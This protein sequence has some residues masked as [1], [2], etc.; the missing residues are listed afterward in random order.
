[1]IVRKFSDAT[2]QLT[3]ISILSSFVLSVVFGGVILIREIR[4]TAS[5]FVEFSTEEARTLSREMTKSNVEPSSAHL[6]AFLESRADV[7]NGH[8]LKAQIVS[9]TGEILADTVEDV[10]TDSSPPY[11]LKIEEDSVG[12][13][14]HR[15][16]WGHQVTLELMLPV[17][18]ADGVIE[19]HLR[20]M[21]R[22]NQS[23]VSE[24]QWSVAGSVGET[25]LIV[26][27]TAGFIYPMVRRLNQNLMKERQ[28]MLEANIAILDGLGAAIAQRDSD[29]GSHNYR[30]TYYSIRLA[31]AA[32]LPPEQI[33]SLIKGAFLH[34]VGKIGVRD[35]ILLKPGKLTDVEFEEMKTHVD[36]GLRIVKQVAWLND[37]SD[38]VGGHHEKWNGSGYPNRLSKEN[39]P[40]NARVFAVA[41]VFDALTSRRP[42]KEPFPV[43]QAESIL[44]EGRN[45]HFDP[46]LVDLF[47]SRCRSLM[48]ETSELDETALKNLLRAAAFPYFETAN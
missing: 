21:Y 27:L 24:A 38:V 41:D 34:D 8:L 45:Q 40:L 5:K 15:I 18:L 4:N 19:E 6:R 13:V 43:E 22:V 46:E 31:E 33:R 25:I 23:V 39:I 32:G 35:S 7:P 44:M 26:I 48:R 9:V 20:V 10:K 14:R 3:R 12:Q 47:L 28:R 16:D 17:V 1:M 36:H 30:V 29:T 11:E 42:Y 2:K 37:A